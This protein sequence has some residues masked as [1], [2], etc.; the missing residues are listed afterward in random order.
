MSKRVK[1]RKARK[2][3]CFR[4]YLDGAPTLSKE[5]NMPVENA[6]QR[7]ISEYIEAPF[8][9][10][11]ESSLQGRLFELVN[12]ELGPAHRDVAAE[13]HLE[14][15]DH[16]FNHADNLRT[17]RTQLEMKIGRCGCN[18]HGKTDLL[19]LRDDLPVELTCHRNGPADVIAS[20]DAG[21]VQA[22]VE[23]KAC[24]SSMPD[25]QVQ[26]RADVE[27][28]QALVNAHPHIAGHFVFL[29]TSVSIPPFAIANPPRQSAWIQG[30]PLPIS[31]ARPQGR[32][33]VEIWDIN[34]ELPGQP[35]R[36]FY[37]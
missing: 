27:K 30:M 23:M 8:R 29:D 35:R 9:Y 19:V 34:P 28:L 33:V 11:R 6:I 4:N 24:P 12:L 13:I 36:R 31:E 17:L 15:E 10:V 22:A 14:P 25:Q 5:I 16:N 2:L 3:A 32:N 21:N 7:L 37:G 20:I 18:G 1:R 26:C